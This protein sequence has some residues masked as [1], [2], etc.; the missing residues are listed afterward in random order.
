[1]K[2]RILPGTIAF[3]LLLG[4]GASAAAASS[5]GS[6]PGPLRH[7]RSE[8]LRIEKIASNGQLPAKFSCSNATAD[9]ARITKA[10]TKINALLVRAQ[11]A[12]TTATSSGKTHRAAFIAD[13]IKQATV[14]EQALTKVSSLISTT[15]PG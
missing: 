2:L 6:R 9:L 13:K 4:V 11:L 10:E 3:I 12:E 7:L 1:M 14:F 8:V 5:H 15:C